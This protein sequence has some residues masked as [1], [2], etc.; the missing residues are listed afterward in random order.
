MEPIMLRIRKTIYYKYTLVWCLGVCLYPT[1]VETA[2]TNFVWDLTS[3]SQKKNRKNPP[4]FE[5]HFKWLTFRAT[6][7]S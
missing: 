2:G 6:V 4:K 3:K 5:N 7:N 1:N